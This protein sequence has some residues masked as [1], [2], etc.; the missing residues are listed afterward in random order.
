MQFN[1]HLRA[2]WVILQ[3]GGWQAPYLHFH[4][5]SLQLTNISW[6]GACN[7]IWCPLCF[8]AT[9]T[10][11][12]A[13]EGNRST[14]QVFWWKRLLAS[15]HRCGPMGR[16]LIKHTSK[17]ADYK[18]LQQLGGWVLSS[19]SLSS[20]PEHQYLLEGSFYTFGA[21]VFVTA[22]LDHL[23]PVASGVYDWGLTRLNICIP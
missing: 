22:N 9:P 6:K 16:L 10:P 13:Q 3:E 11:H 19:C 4:A 17:M 2:C 20:A 14:S 7:L 8:A 23:V 12:R 18:P 15:P 5:A 1:T 21:L